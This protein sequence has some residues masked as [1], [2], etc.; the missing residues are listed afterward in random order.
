MV[1]LSRGRVFYYTVFSEYYKLGDKFNEN[2]ET[3]WISKQEK[4]Q[5][6]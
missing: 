6:I 1:I 2:Q 3:P 5:G 4:N